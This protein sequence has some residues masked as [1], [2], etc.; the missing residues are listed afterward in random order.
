MSVVFVQS[1]LRRYGDFEA[2]KD[3]DLHVDAGEC[4]AMLG[5]NGAGKTTVVEILEGFRHRDGGDVRVLDVDPAH[6]NRAW[7]QRLGIV[8]QNASD[9]DDAT[10]REA[11]AHFSKL[12]VHPRH[13]D[14]TINLVGL[15]EKSSARVATLSGG[16]RRRLDVALGVIG[17]PEILFLD[18]PTTGFDPE[19]RH[20]FWLLIEQLKSEG[21]TIVLTTHYLEEADA[22][23]DRVVVISRGK[24]IADTTPADLGARSGNQVRVKWREGG[25]THEETTERPTELVTQ[26]AARLGG[27]IAGLE[28]TRTTLEEAYLAL[29]A[30]EESRP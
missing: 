25:T 10:V 11:I 19:A 21:V 6:G 14:D 30:D 28:V 5:P 2:V 17:R 12:Y 4:V 29:I 23:S 22:L 26:L 1:L 3:F 7:R 24:K 13:V 18:E 8:T 20:H 16:Q 27:E 9:L 15:T